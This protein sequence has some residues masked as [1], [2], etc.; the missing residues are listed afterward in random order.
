MNI[1]KLPNRLVSRLLYKTKL[2]AALGS[3]TLTLLVLAACAPAGSPTS[4][5]VVPTSF[6]PTEIYTP[7]EPTPLS[8]SERSSQFEARTIIPETIIMDKD[9][10]MTKTPPKPPPPGSTEN[11]LV[12]FAKE[13]LAN[14]LGIP[15]EQIELI[16][17]EHVTWPDGSLG[18]PEP[19]VEHIQVQREGSLI[20]LRVGKTIYQYHS[21]GGRPP[22]LCEHPSVGKDLPPSSGLGNE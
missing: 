15:V 12:N 17:M 3:L 10:K 9:A 1:T 22:F 8:T 14:H 2:I 5:Q 20:R 7:M 18:C 4:P 21:G 6:S 19:G 16:T 13:D 11:Q